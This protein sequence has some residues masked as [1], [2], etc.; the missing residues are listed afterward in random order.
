MGNSPAA[1]QFAKSAGAATEG[2]SLQTRAVTFAA[3]GRRQQHG[4]SSLAPKQ[5]LMQQNGQQ[6]MQQSA[7]QS[8]KQPIEQTSQ[9]PMQQ[10]KKQQ[11]QL[12]KKNWVLS[13]ATLSHEVIKHL[14]FTLQHQAQEHLF[15]EVCHATAKSALAGA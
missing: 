12:Q 15:L 6:P 5:Q 3:A 1:D 10:T 7:H 2:P 9:Q 11:A 4:F 13:E 14:D 8:N